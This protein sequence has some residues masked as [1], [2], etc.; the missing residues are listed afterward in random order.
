MLSGQPAPLFTV[1]SNYMMSYIALAWYLVNHSTIL[2]ALLSFRPIL[3]I[4]AFGATAAKVRSILS[5]MDSFV[6]R[7]PD[8]VLGAIVL[9]GL[10]GSGGALFVTMEKIVQNGF[11][12]P[13]ELSAPGWGFKSAYVAA[14]AYYVGT[15]PVGWIAKH[16]PFEIVTIER[17]EMRFAV[18]LALCIHAALER[19]YG[20]HVNP[21]YAVEEVLYA[22]TGVRKIAQEQ[23]V[24]AVPASPVEE[25]ISKKGDKKTA[26]DL[27]AEGLRRR[28]GKTQTE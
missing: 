1:S 16:V 18:A 24:P 9:S 26:K 22:L 25:E 12:T 15:D 17:E 11:D 2:R 13:S 8:A 19:L 27:Q 23:E 21:L 4:I 3:A 10:A 28:K 5:F 20:R 14:L 6:V 7:F